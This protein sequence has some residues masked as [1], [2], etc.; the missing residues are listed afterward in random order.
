MKAYSEDLRERVAAA[1]AE[2]RHSVGDVATQFRV[3][4]SFVHKLRRRQ[5]TTGSFAAL[6]HRGG[7]RPTSGLRGP[8]TRC[9][10]GRIAR[11]IDRRRRPRRGPH[12]GLAAVANAGLAAQKKSVPAAERDT[13]R[14]KGLRRTFLEQLPAQDVTRFKFVDETSVNLTDTRRYGRAAGGQRVGQGVALHNGPNVTL[15]AALTP[16]GLEAVM[17]LDGAVNAARFAVYLDQVLG[18]TLV[19]GDVGVLDNLRV[20]HVA[21]LAE[22]VE[23]RGARLLFLPPDSP[24]FTPVERA[25]SQLKTSLRWSAARTREALTDAVRVAIGWVTTQDVQGWFHHCGYHVH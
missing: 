17:E 21:G 8:A 9:D 19:P 24:D 23:A 5:R 2:E 6:P 1:C 7:P 14:V 3:S 11:P 15:M 18:P 4:V 10:A 13:E 12:D 20:H 22:L 16:Q 25:F